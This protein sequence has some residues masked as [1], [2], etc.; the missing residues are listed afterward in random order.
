MQLGGKSCEDMD[1]FPPNGLQGVSLRRN[2]GCRE[3]NALTKRCLAARSELTRGSTSSRWA[4]SD[5]EVT[6]EWTK[7]RSNARCGWFQYRCQTR[8]HEEDARCD[9]SE[10]ELREREEGEGHGGGG[11]G[12]GG[13]DKERDFLFA[14][15]ALPMF[16]P[17]CAYN[18]VGTSQGGE[19]SGSH[20]GPLADSRGVMLC[21]SCHSL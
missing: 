4:C 2:T 7:S 1:V 12:G 9:E 6:L 10:W 8:E 17:W 21:V 16:L 5:W 11:R 13:L 14:S 15:T 20:N 3:S 19:C 18:L